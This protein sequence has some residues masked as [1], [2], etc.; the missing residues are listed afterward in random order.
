ML[1][2]DERVLADRARRK[3]RGVGVEEVVVR[4][5]LPL[6]AGE[7]GER[8]RAR[9]RVDVEG[10]ALV[11]VLPVAQRPVELVREGSALGERLAESSREPA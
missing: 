2:D 5:L 3:E 7:A 10:A 6:V 1:D 4:K 8:R 11:R 9:G